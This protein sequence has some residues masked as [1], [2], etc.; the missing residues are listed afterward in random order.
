M[1]RGEIVSQLA[2]GSSVGNNLDPS[3]TGGEGQGIYTAGASLLDGLQ[4]CSRRQVADGSRDDHA[5]KDS[6][7]ICHISLPRLGNNV[8]VHNK[9]ISPFY[10][11]LVY[12]D[13]PSLTPTIL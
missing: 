12:P 6:T 9:C 3:E 10:S 11:F 4:V 5:H 13:W 1:V 8:S 7:H 2:V